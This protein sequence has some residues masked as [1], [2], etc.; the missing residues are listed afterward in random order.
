MVGCQMKNRESRYTMVPVTVIQQKYQIRPASPD[1]GSR[2][3]YYIY[4]LPCS[5][6]SKT[7]G[8]GHVIQMRTKING[9]LLLITVISCACAQASVLP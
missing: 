4:S 6:L 2:P 7:G 8:A 9:L 1:P 3:G 5:V